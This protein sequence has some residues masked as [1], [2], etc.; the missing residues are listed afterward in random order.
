M[1][2]Q[3]ECKTI[4]DVNHGIVAEAQQ[5]FDHVNPSAVNVGANRDA[6]LFLKQTG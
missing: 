1:A 3:G 2:L 5:I 6:G 4:G